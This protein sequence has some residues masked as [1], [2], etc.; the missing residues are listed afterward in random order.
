MGILKS[1]RKKSC[2]P[3]RNGGKH[4]A[5]LKN[6]VVKPKEMDFFQKLSQPAD[7]RLA[8]FSDVDACYRCTNITI[9]AE[10]WIIHTVDQ[11]H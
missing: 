10:M 3:P 9:G 5:V 7:P 2:G 6:F 11:S 1:A 4:K 8:Y